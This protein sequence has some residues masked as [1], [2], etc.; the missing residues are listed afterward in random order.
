MIKRISILIILVS[1]FTVYRTSSQ[2]PEMNKQII[3][4]VNSVMGK[5][6]DR[7]EC[8]DLANKALILV[9][10]DW[11]GKFTYGKL[12][13]PKKDSIYPGDIIQYK[14][15]VVKYTK[16]NVQYKETMKQH[17]AIVYKVISK[18]NYEVAE[19]NTAYAGK[20]VS[21]GKLNLEYIE[22]GKVY[23]YRPVP[24]EK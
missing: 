9:K 15:V 24:Y 5:K 14:D 4:Y 2:I 22:K 13:N 8:W 17:T 1:F 21:I 20:K 12:L 11:D 18:G 6:V 16:G 19:Q 23:I 3:E 7:G 10:A